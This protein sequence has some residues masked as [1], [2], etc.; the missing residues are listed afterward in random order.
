MAGRS[1]FL[2]AVAF[3]GHPHGVAAAVLL[4]ACWCAVGVGLDFPQEWFLLTNML[5]TLVVLLLLLL[6]QHSQNRDMRALQAK[7]DELI[8]STIANITDDRRRAA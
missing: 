2:R 6:M 3:A 7:A 1:R 8:R 4:A 5:C